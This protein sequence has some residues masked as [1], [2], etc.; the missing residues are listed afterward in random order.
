M[1]GLLLVLLCSGLTFL[2]TIFGSSIVYFCK[3]INLKFEKT[4][5]GFASG[6]MIA[7]SFFSLILP[8][9]DENKMFS[10]FGIILGC[11]L[12]YILKIINLKIKKENNSLFFLA[13]CKQL[14]SILPKNYL[15]VLPYPHR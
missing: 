10:I 6:I 3:N 4:C 11:I 9:I 12:I 5:L 13:L 8:A 15:T 2:A 7:A 1:N 14:S